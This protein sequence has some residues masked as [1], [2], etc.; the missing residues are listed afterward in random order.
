MSCSYCERKIESQNV[1]ILKILHLQTFA[2]FK[3]SFLKT[4]HLDHYIANELYGLHFNASQRNES[5]T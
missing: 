5:E 1:K 3:L 4:V 2:Y